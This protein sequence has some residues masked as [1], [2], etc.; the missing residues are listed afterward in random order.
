MADCVRVIQLYY[1][2]Q[3]AEEVRRRWT[4]TSS[5]SGP[6][7]SSTIRRL[8]V[9]FERTGSVLH[10]G[11]SGRPR[12]SSTEEAKTSVTESVKKKPTA[13][14]RRRSA[15]MGLSRSSLQRILHELGLRPY[16]PKLIHGLLED[17]FSRRMEFCEKFL[18]LVESDH[19][20]LDRIMWSDEATFKLN[21][22]VNRHNSIY[23]ATDNPHVAISREMNAPGVTVWAAIS[24]KGTI[25]PCFFE[26]TVNGNSYLTMLKTEMWPAVQHEATRRRLFFMQDG[27]PPHW[28]REVR[29]WLDMKF[30]ERWIGRGGPVDWPPRSPDLTPCD[31]FL[32]GV[33]KEKV[34]AMEPKTIEDLKKAITTALHALTVELC[35]KVCHSV[36]N[37]CEKCI[38]LEGEHTEL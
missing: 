4:S 25:G 18:A 22:H 6:P 7:A 3:N 28:A 30:P 33:L 16:I 27:A 11:V 12:S 13:S 9:K 37:R 15:E 31:F 1:K 17:D 14:I 20:L 5:S 2:C 24:A 38:E 19:S 32:W 10:A 8:V 29:S 21:G 23:W 36:A 26:G 35:E 34:Y